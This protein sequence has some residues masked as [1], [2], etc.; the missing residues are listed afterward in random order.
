M[1]KYLEITNRNDLAFDTC[2]QDVTSDQYTAASIRVVKD[3]YVDD[4][5]KLPPNAYKPRGIII[6]INC[7]VDS[8]N[9][10]DNV[11]SRSHTS[12]LFY[13]NDTPIIF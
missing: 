13:F 8:D 1:F 7:F 2:C 4:I 11:N 9:A 6:Q 10:S 5:N 12:V 3:L